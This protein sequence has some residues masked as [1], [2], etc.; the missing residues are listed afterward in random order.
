MRRLVVLM[1]LSLVL[2]TGAAVVRSA[3]AVGASFVIARALETGLEVSAS[4]SVSLGGGRPGATPS[5]QLTAVTVRDSRPVNPNTWTATVTSTA[6][7]TGTGT[8][9]AT[10]PASQLSYW[11][12]PAI[13]STGGGNLI[14]GQPT[15]PQAQTLAAPRVAF[16]KT[17][18][19]ANNRVTWSPGLVLNL[20]ATAVSGLY[21]GTVT[22]SVS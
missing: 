2:V 7:T 17:S 11:S 5:R 19:N 21:R 3:P 15:R 8:S 14:P 4:A 20:P 12:G 1:G 9:T 6:F 10:I 22:H 18:G 16:R 13:R